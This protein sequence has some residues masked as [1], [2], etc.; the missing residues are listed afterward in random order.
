MKTTLLGSSWKATLKKAVPAVAASVMLSSAAYGAE[1]S[2]LNGLY[3]SAKSDTS[4]DVSQ[5][6]LG[7]RY[8]T[9][10]NSK[11]DIYFQ[12]DVQV[13]SFSGDNAPDSVTGLGLEVG[14]RHNLNHFGGRIIPYLS[15]G[16]GIEANKIKNNS[17]NPIT[18]R[19]GLTYNGKI[20]FKTRLGG[21][22][23]VDLET[24]LFNSD[25]MITEKTGNSE[26]KKTEIFAGTSAQGVF[27]NATLSLGMYM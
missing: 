24:A 7:A 18:E 13:V 21:R 5:I 15:G 20:G 8:L 14:V 9:G 6:L 27:D 12:G 16:V 1:L 17:F 2:L 11:L 26:V 23:F 4:F 3:K 10:L 19:S 22:F 25:L